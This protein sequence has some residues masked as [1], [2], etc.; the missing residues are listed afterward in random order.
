MHRKIRMCRL[1]L[2]NLTYSSS[3]IQ[4]Q[5]ETVGDFHPDVIVTLDNLAFCHVKK[6]DY[7]KALKYYNETL[8]AQVAFYGEFTYQCAKTKRKEQIVFKK[9]CSSRQA[10]DRA[11]TA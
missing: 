1:S 9:Y 2:A 5:R 3:C 4:L 10:R 6:R 7:D 11:F 8:Q